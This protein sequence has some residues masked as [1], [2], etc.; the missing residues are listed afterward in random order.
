MVLVNA[1]EGIAHFVVDSGSVGTGA[2]SAIRDAPNGRS[3]KKTRYVTIPSARY[4]RVETLT[5]CRLSL[6]SEGDR[7]IGE[8][9][10]GQVQKTPTML[11]CWKE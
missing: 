4:L 2:T 11:S 1:Y 9:R 5:M 7:T 3:C 6:E 8:Y 10:R